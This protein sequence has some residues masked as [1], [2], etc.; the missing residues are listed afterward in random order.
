MLLLSPASV[1]SPWV[2]RELLYALDESRYRE[3]IAPVT[4]RRCDPDPLSWT[5][6]ALQMIDLTTDFEQGCRELLALWPLNARTA[7][8]SGRK[9]SKR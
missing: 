4:I 3:R 9:R 2:K 6:R 7:R 1:A 8:K 5:L